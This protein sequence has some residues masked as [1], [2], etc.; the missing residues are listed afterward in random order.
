MEKNTQPLETF[1]TYA[2]AELEKHQ[3]ELQTRYQDRELSSDDMK[4]EAYRKQRQVFEKEL[5]EKMMELSGDSNQFLHASLTELKEKF[6]DRL[7]PES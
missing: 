2:E 5:S 1:R 6:V 4:E 3:R 7:R